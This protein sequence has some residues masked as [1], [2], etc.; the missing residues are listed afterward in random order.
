[1]KIIH[2]IWSLNT[3]GSEAMLVDI[4]NRQA[5]SEHVTVIIGNDEVDRN[6]IGA[7][8]ENVRVILIGRPA[9][10][11]NPWYGLKLYACLKRL[12][13]DVLHAHHQSFIELIRYLSVPK[14]V[15]IHTTRILLSSAARNYDRVFCISSAVKED[16]NRRYPWLDCTMVH[17]GIDFSAIA[18]KTTYGNAHFRIV[19]VS[20]LDSDSKGQ[21]IL[22]RAL[23]CLMRRC[24]DLPVSV[25]FIGKGESRDGLASLAEELG[26]SDRCRFLGACPRA[27]LYD[28]LRCY[29]LLVQPS[30][31]EGFGLTIVEAMAA[32]VPVLVSD[33]EGPMEI[34]E[35]GRYGYV[36]RVGDAEDCADKILEIIEHSRSREM[37]W[38]MNRNR[39]YAKDRFDIELTAGK[40]LQE[41]R[42]LVRNDVSGQRSRRL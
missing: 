38:E 41:Y 23:E 19:Q 36:F 11:Q 34:I 5:Q 6:L 18:Q 8:H 40:Y 27:H 4:V 9:G 7:I 13:P 3:G 20:R 37:A 12:K 28:H 10:N 21:D 1:M 39:N 35:G 17:N 15:T 30:R 22:L 29:D 2:L 14:T 16:L 31:Y 42:D 32:R 24:G 26:V 33:V 25:D